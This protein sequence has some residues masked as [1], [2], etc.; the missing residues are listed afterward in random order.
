MHLRGV[1]LF[2]FVVIASGL[3]IHPFCSHWWRTVISWL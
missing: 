1:L 3:L 2:V